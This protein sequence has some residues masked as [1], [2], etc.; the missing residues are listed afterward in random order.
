M[1]YVG[2]TALSS[3]AN[4]PINLIRGV[5]YQSPGGNLFYSSAATSYAAFSGGNGLWY[6]QSTD[7]TSVIT[8]TATYFT[9]GLALGMRMGDACMVMSVTS[10]GATAGPLFGIGVLYS[11]NSTAGFSLSTGTLMYSTA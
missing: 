11:T 1:A 10:A 4:P 5:G 9:D 8:G 6:Y 7:A 2:S 3:V